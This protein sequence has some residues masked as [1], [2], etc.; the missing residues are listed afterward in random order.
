MV[1]KKGTD[2]A[3]SHPLN[4]KI[5]NSTIEELPRAFDQAPQAAS[6]GEILNTFGTRSLPW[7]IFL[8]LLSEDPL[9]WPED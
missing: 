3:N 1:S 2:W 9:D 7:R 6:K 5:V 8:G 4:L